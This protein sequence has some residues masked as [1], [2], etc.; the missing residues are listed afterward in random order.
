MQRVLLG[1][2]VGLTLSVQSGPAVARD[3]EA[4]REIYVGQCA[5]CHGSQAEGMGGMHPALQGAVARLTREGV[6]VTVRN[7]R[8]TMPPMPA[9]ADRLSSDEIADVTAYLASLPHGPRNFG[10][11]QDGMMRGPGMMPGMDRMSSAGPWLLLSALAVLFA[12][13]VGGLVGYLLGRS[14]GRPQE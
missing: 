3:A 5:M 9:F 10:P 11:E 6:E 12:G 2:L 1:L 14:R 8:D 4:G 7:G 13:V